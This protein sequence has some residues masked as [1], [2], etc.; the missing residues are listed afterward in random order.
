[1]VCKISKIALVSCTK[2]KQNFL[3]E[4]Q[5]MYNKSALFSKVIQ[6]I[7]QCEY[8]DW[9]I[10]SAK[11]GLIEKDELIEPYDITLNNMKSDERKAWA[12]EVAKNIL[13]LDVSHIDFYAGQ[14][15]RQYLIPLLELKGIICAIP[16]EGLGIGEQLKYLNEN[17]LL[18]N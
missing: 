16:L 1:M 13:T 15:Y 17:N 9:Y 3:C 18:T 6:L 7:R 14:K 8:T 5:T 10:L 4:A 12:K 2:I 11:Y